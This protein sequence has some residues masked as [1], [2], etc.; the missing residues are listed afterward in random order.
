MTP[1]EQLVLER[2]LRLGL[3]TNAGTEDVNQGRTLLAE[4][5]DDG[6]TGRG[7][8]S[9]EHVAENAQHAVEAL[10][11]GTVIVRL[12]RDTGHHLREH[13]Q[14]NDQGRRQERILADVEQTD[15]LVATH[16]DLGIV[17]VQCALVVTDG[18]HVLDDDSVVGVLVLLVQKVVGSDHVI[19]NVGL[20]D[21]LGAELLLGAQVLAVVVTQM[22]VTGDGGE[23]DTGI[24]QEV[25]QSRLHLGLARLEVVAADKGTALL[26]ELK[27]TGHKRVLGR[28]VDEG[29]VLQDGGHGK[30][31]GRG[32]LGMAGLDRVDQV[33]GGVVDARNDV[34]IPF[35]VGGPHDDHL[36]QVVLSLEVTDILLDPLHVSPAGLVSLDDVVRTILLVGG[37][38]IGVVDTGQRGH[39]RHLLADLTL[40]ARLQH[41]CTVHGSCQI[42]GADVPTSNG[43]VV[44]VN[45]GKQVTERD[46]DLLTSLGISAQLDGGAHDNGAVVVGL[47]LTL[48]GLPGQTTAVGKDTG[49]DGGT[50]VSTPA[51]QH[52]TDL[53][54]LTVDLEVVVGGLGDGHQL[55]VRSASHLGSL[56][57][58][59]TL[60]LIRSVDDIGRLNSKQRRRFLANRPVRSAIGNIRGSVRS[61]CSQRD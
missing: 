32:D 52:H 59:L 60:D 25:H 57:G 40:E 41:L 12:P 16:E 15:G 8:G 51:D 44:G 2:H 23:L 19:H 11:I 50:V 53:A 4:G 13:D 31:G 18:G 14:I 38:E 1:L 58:I 20:G 45:H 5:V 37:D 22:V 42:H 9:L 27:S 33:V 46:V 39:L 47:L 48:A 24:D 55:V 34:G 49:S 3:K 30:D 36:V 61:H 7:Q 17:L 35:S 26:R 28:A 10:V 29:C 21:L 54:H 43:H 56:V 6:S